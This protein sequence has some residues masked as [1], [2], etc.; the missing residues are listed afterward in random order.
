M[1]RPQLRT[2]ILQLNSTKNGGG[3]TRGRKRY[4]RVKFPKGSR[5]IEKKIQKR[6]EGGKAQPL[7][8]SN[9]VA[10][11]GG[12]REP[13]GAGIRRAPF[14]VGRVFVFVG[15]ALGGGGLLWATFARWCR[16][17]CL[18][19]GGGAKSR[20][21]CKNS[22]RF[23]NGHRVQKF[24]FLVEGGSTTENPHTILVR[25]GQ[26]GGVLK[27]IS[28]GDPTLRRG[29]QKRSPKTVKTWFAAKIA[30]KLRK[31]RFIPPQSAL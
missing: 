2:R 31:S 22:L 18:C 17:P 13:G 5:P 21:E 10:G 23:S 20:G 19:A 6:E 14:A 25:K 8:E 7:R 16:A 30:K 26:L 1:L 4:S 27:T 28:D 3:R 12:A 11:G 29:R 15:V 9:P 24:A